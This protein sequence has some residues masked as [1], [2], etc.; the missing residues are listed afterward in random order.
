MFH[1]I[2]KVYLAPD[3]TIDMAHDRVIISEENG[4]AAFEFIEKI[5]GG[6]LHKFGHTV[7]D[8]VGED[9]VQFF[10]DLIESSSQTGR[11]VYIYADAVALP[12]IQAL[13]FKLTL[14][15]IDVDTCFKIY[16]ANV[17]KYNL[18]YKT[19]LISS[20][21]SRY[22][23]HSIDPELI[24]PELNSV[25]DLDLDESVRTAFC[26][27]HKN[28]LGIEYLLANY[29]YNGTFKDELKTSLKR[30]MRK[31]FDGILLEYKGTFLSYYTNDDFAERVQLEHRYSFDNLSDLSEDNSDIVE[32]FLSKRLYKTVEL[33]KHSSNSNFV[34]E[35]MTEDDVE[36][37]RMFT[38]ALG[39]HYSFDTS[40]PDHTS[41]SPLLRD[42]YKWQFLDC[43]RGEF[44]DA[45]LDSMIEV[46]AS[47]NYADGIFYNVLLETVNGF[48]IQHILRLHKSGDTDKLRKFIVFE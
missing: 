40:T 26:E 34:F 48:T 30:I 20:S 13:W 33:T 25:I 4:F 32:F 47:I 21:G 11:S 10:E 36:T 16:N 12:K 37:L 29:I 2:G 14:A 15:N 17:Q 35:N 43:I 22:I 1:L 3:F 46:E 42:G 7:E 24:R 5:M 6:T 18:F 44:T 41:V 39:S 38:S 45:L 31:H 8:V 27:K 23:T 28:I 19:S 9:F